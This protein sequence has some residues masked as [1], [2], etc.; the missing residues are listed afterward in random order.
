MTVRF[1]GPGRKMFAACELSFGTEE[2]FSGLLACVDFLRGGD[3]KEMYLEME[4]QDG[5]LLLKPWRNFCGCFFFRFLHHF[6]NRDG[7]SV[8]V[9]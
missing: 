9:A 5:L 8:L 6:G 2:D 4:D 1:L 7:D 3:A